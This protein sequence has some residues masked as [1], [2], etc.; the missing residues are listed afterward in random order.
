MPKKTNELWERFYISQISIKMNLNI[1][2][3]STIL[4]IITTITTTTI[5]K[6]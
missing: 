2:L 6:L 1:K 3:H 5:T 4:L